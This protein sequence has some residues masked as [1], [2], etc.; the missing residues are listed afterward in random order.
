MHD[1]IIMAEQDQGKEDGGLR[2]L[3][4]AIECNDASLAYRQ[5]LL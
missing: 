2:P 5:M 3:D 4:G 1:P